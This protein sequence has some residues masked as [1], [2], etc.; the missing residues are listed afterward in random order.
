MS[1][2][3][4]NEVKEM[5]EKFSL[6]KFWNVGSNNYPNII[7]ARI[8]KAGNLVCEFLQLNGWT[9]FVEYEG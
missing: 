1:T 4:S 2:Q 8:N 6:M 5:L 9:K 7:S 3:L